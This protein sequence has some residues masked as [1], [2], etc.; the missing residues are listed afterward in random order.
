MEKQLER[1]NLKVFK[2]ELTF[3]S[4]SRTIADLSEEVSRLKQVTQFS[5]SVARL[6]AACVENFGTEQIKDL[7]AS[8]LVTALGELKS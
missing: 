8:A 7:R 1:A 5:E 3:G 2:T 6:P 4:M